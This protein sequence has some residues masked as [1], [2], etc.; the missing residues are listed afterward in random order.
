MSWAPVTVSNQYPCLLKF[1]KK[2]KNLVSLA[3]NL[4]VKFSLFEWMCL[5]DLCLGYLCASSSL[6]P[7]TFLYI[8]TPLHPFLPIKWPISVLGLL[9]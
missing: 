8:L 5:L 1:K 7:S 6:L 4:Q 3:E 9:C 2:K